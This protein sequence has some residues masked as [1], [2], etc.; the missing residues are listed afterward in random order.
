M[1]ITL[2]YDAE[3]LSYTLGNISFRK[4][5]DDGEDTFHKRLRADLEELK[6]KK[7]NRL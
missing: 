3:I 2:H 4:L 5:A 7:N 6:I 1:D